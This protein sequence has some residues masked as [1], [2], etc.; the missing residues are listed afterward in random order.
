MEQRKYTIA[1][2]LNAETEPTKL[3][4]EEID[5]VQLHSIMCNLDEIGDIKEV[6]VL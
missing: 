1:I 3:T 6:T 4:T 5:L 2:L